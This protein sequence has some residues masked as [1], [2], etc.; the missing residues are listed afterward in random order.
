[1][2][3]W[4]DLLLTKIENR[5]LFSV[6]HALITDFISS[7]WYVAT[8]PPPPAEEEEEREGFGA[9]GTEA[10]EAEGD[11]EEGTEEEDG[12]LLMTV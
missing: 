10:G 8:P 1:M 11:E 6:S 9:E 2:M 3:I 4:F 5:H 12:D 7:F